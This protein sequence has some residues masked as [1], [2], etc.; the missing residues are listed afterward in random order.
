[1]RCMQSWWMGVLE[2]RCVDMT[3]LHTLFPVDVASGYYWIYEVFNYGECVAWM[4]VALALPI[5]FRGCPAEK[6]PI[7]FRASA[8]F[9]IFGMS[10][11][12]EA[13][14]HGRLPAWL[15]AVK[16]LCCVYFLKC[17]YDYLGKERFR[18]F[19]RTHVLAL[20][21]FLAALLAIVMQ[22]YILE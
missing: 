9:V 18:W 3:F 12:F 8:A 14:T 7:I 21:C 2:F 15:W 1:M 13:P 5:R 20:G 11:Y 19:D 22:H 6:K 4:L 10:D 16:I 17:R